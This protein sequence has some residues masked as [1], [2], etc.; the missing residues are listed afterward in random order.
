MRMQTC[1]FSGHRTIRADQLDMVAARTERVIRELI[2]TRGIRFFGTGGAI[3]YDYLCSRILFRLRKTDFPQIKV[4]LTYPFE[5]YQDG[6]KQMQRD[7]YAQIWHQFDKRV[8]VSMW[9]AERRF[10]TE[11]GTWWIVLWW[12]AA[13]ENDPVQAARCGMQSQKALP[14]SILRNKEKRRTS[15]WMSAVLEL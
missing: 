11:T 8:C 5:G 7:Q 12:P 9:P 14:D 6:W 2:E 10:W 3:G 15:I 1:C 13:P 4:I